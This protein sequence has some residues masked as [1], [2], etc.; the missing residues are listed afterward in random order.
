MLI[1]TQY[2]NSWYPSLGLAPSLYK[3]Q[4]KDPQIADSR[5]AQLARHWTLKPGII[6]S[7]PTPNQYILIMICNMA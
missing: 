4:S 6:K 7:Y 3:C 2:Y 5:L 1:L